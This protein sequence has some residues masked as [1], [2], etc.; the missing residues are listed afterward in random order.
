MT[1]FVIPIIIIALSILISL[2]LGLYFRYLLVG[3]LKKTVLDNWLIQLLGVLI[4]IPPIIIIPSIIA[5]TIAA[6]MMGI[7]ASQIFNYIQSIL[8]IFFNLNITD[9]GSFTRNLIVS[10]LIILLAI[11][12]GRTLLK[13]VT[14]GAVKN[15]VSINI[16]I[17]IGRICYVVVMI[18]ASIWI[19]ALWD[20]SFTLPAAIISIVTVGLTFVLQDLL[21][22]LVAGLYILVEGPFHIGDTISTSDYS[23][24]VEN[25]QLRATKLRIVSGEQV[26]VPNSMLFSD[27]VIN[28]SIYDE[29][30]ATIIIT[31]PQEEYDKAQITERILN[32]IKE[33]NG[34]LPKPEPTLSLSGIAGSFGSATGT[35][36]G[37]TGEIITL[38][39]HFWTPE[40]QDSVV[41][42][43][44]IALRTALPRADL[45]MREPTQM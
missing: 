36:S 40:G 23:G 41:S 38:T 21:K 43:A 44:L 24:K 22:N 3:R 7:E 18:I 30:R 12:V 1:D 4:I 33:L 37:Y 10:A 9:W 25:V 11:G 35:V 5:A 6:P 8:R 31:M 29:R 39:L 14:A 15:H 45:S 27:I 13:L 16:R 32:T 2:G 19:L 26:I 42:E 17:L 28:K 20:L 34:V